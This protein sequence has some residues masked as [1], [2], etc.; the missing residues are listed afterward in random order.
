MLRPDPR[1]CSGRPLGAS[2]AAVL[3]VL[4]SLTACST[5]AAERCLVSGAG[6]PAESRALREACERA[7]PAVESLWPGWTGEVPIVRTSSA[8]PP[9][10]A[11]QVEGRVVP[12]QPAEEDRLVVGPDVVRQ[13]SPEG[14]DVVM[15]HELTHVAMRSTGTAAVPSW[16]SEGLAEYAGYEGVPDD[17]RERREDLLSLRAA[18]DAGIW[19]G[20]LPDPAQ[21]QDPDTRVLAYTAGWLGIVVLIEAFGLDAVTE[22]M[23][24]VDGAEQARDDQE[25]ADAFLQRLGVQREWLEGRWHSE[26]ERRVE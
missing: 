17:R 7:V 22:A 19:V 3:L 20:A 26:L 8:L 23:R 9:G 1:P 16:A 25:R 5:A 18:V 11:A 14:L 10:I 15:R 13:L 24:P 12:G 2:L 6:S 4:T 21:L